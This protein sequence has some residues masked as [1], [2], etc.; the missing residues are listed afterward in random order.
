MRTQYLAAEEILVIHSEIIDATGGS[1]GLRDSGLLSSV[2]ER[3]KATF[4][5]KELYRGIFTKAA[6]YMESFARFH[7]FIDG[8]KRTA[9]TSAA[10]FLSKN[11]YELYADN[12]EVGAFTL[13]AATGEAELGDIALWLEKHSQKIKE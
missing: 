7:V 4:K 6:V 12:S 10:R 9:I 5:G 11:G 1:H 8:N 3:P 13:K 2:T